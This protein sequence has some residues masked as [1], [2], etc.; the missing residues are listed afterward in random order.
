MNTLGWVLAGIVVYWLAVV[1][2]RS[3]GVLPDYVRTQGPLLTLRTG[4]GRDLLDRLADRERF[5]RA[6]ANFGLG[7]ALVV[8]ALAFVF[9]VL[10]AIT[11]MQ[12][13]TSSAVTEPQNVL[14]IPG[15]NEF[16][17]L[18]VAPEILAGLLVGLVVH[19]GGHGLL[20][21]VE[22]ID[23]ESMGVV[24]FAL[25]PI[26]AFVEPDEESRRQAG[27]GSQ[28]RM[29]AAGV[30]NNFAVTV[31]A[32]ALLFGPVTGSMAVAS[33]AQVGDVLDGSAADD[34]DLQRGDRITAVGGTPVEGNDDLDAALSNETGRTV[35]VEVN[36]GERSVDVERSL[37]VVGVVPEA[38]TGVAR[39]QTI[40]AVNGS[41]VGTEQEFR[42][43]VDERAVATVETADGNASTFPV[44]AFATVNTPEG[45]PDQPTPM[46]NASVPTDRPVTIT[47]V[48][49]ERTPSNE[50]LTRVLQGTEPGQTVTVEAYVDG[51]RDRWNVTL[52]THPADGVDR[53]F[54]GITPTRG[55]TGLVLNDFGVRSYPADSY[56]SL[57]GG[58]DRFTGSVL[59][60]SLLVLAMPVAGVSG[61]LLP[62]NF[63]GWTGGVANFYEPTGPLGFMGGLLF[64]LA[65]LLFWVG[66]INF[67]LAFFNCIPG[68][69]LDGGHILRNSTE[70]VVSRLPVENGRRL[71]TAVTTSIGLTMLLSLGL[72][73]FGEGLLA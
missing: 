42:E 35:A 16:L 58:D 20:C 52:A 8:M 4:R 49:G 66:W 65:N 12:S 68:Y 26:G 51:E 11:Q 6:W 60:R 9:L 54:L 14:V 40:V 29:F 15:V 63:A 27:R 24:L 17:P 71:T 32:F 46:A 5:W 1:G 30:T 2:L 25:L 73:L 23:I 33:G 70:A 18:S 34:A 19:E 50:D 13:E 53:G 41:P 43:A 55:Y 47:R 57:L 72:M 7:V 10:T 67:N 61:G 39:R 28:T 21:R 48:G 56:L 59:Q 22:G 64:V 38:S 44:G 62:Y 69:P 45:T 37:Y 31:V 36:D 3:K